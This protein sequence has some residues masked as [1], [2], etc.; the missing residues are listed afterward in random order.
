MFDSGFLFSLT[1]MKNLNIMM[2]IIMKSFILIDL[3]N[4]G[5][6]N[7]ICIFCLFFHLMI[8]VIV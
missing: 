2:S 3:F 7:D 4:F 5:I 8:F 6:L 1:V